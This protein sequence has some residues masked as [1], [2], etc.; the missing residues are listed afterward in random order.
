MALT[1]TATKTLQQKIAGILGMYK[2]ILISVSPCKKNIMYAIAT[3]YSSIEH[4]FQPLLTRLRKER[5][6]MSRIII[7]CRKYEDC[8]DLYMYFRDELGE[9]FTEPVQSPDLSKFRLVDMFTAVTD[10]EV[11]LQIIDSFCNPS[12][13]LRIVCATIAFGMGIDCADVREVIHFGVPD[14]T[15]SYIQETGRA[16]R[17]GRPSLAVIVPTSS[18]NRK[19]DK[20]MTAYQSNQ[21]ICRRD[22]LFS[23]MDNY[24]HEDNGKCL[25]CDICMK[26]CNCGSCVDKQ[27]SFIFP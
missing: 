5:V 16:G 6:T 7:Y 11:K 26:C 20:S 22:I 12:A 2:P 4:T 27:H 10:T 3:S 13:P 24:S 21:L 14:D 18:A 17:D 19:A 9:D 15:E 8:A 25:C 1:A 23:D